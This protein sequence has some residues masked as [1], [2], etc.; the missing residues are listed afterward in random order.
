MVLF[1]D[2]KG[3]LQSF[4]NLDLKQIEILAL[5]ILKPGCRQC[6][7]KQQQNLLLPR[8][9]WWARLLEMKPNKINQ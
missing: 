1:H 7:K 9:L 3:C 6:T 2:I 8:K 5:Q 4:G